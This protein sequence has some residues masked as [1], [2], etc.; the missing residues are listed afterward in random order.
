MADRGRAQVD[1]D[2]WQLP[3][4]DETAGTKARR[5]DLTIAWQGQENRVGPLRHFDQ[6]RGHDRT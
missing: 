4:L 1:D 3:R 6:R 2:P 5:F